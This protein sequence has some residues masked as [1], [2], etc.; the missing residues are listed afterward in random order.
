MQRFGTAE[1]DASRRDFTIN[2]MFYNVNRRV[3]EDLT[4]CGY[5]DLMAGLLRTPLPPLT[6]F[7]DD[8]LRVMRAVRFASRFGFALHDDIL[9]AVGDEGIQVTCVRVLSDENLGIHLHCIAHVCMH[10]A[11]SVDDEGEQ[12]KD[13]WGVG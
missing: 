10:T 3:I 13:R 12:G 4:G 9:K 6:T 1:E 11:E 2:A 8:P 7:R 5:T